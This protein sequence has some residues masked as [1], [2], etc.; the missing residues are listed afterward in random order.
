MIIM[1]L[2]NCYSLSELFLFV[3]LSVPSY[4][5]FSAFFWHILYEGFFHILIDAALRF[6]LYHGIAVKISLLNLITN[7]PQKLVCGG[8]AALSFLYCYA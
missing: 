3:F 2:C 5:Y 6:C 1:K 8:L 7:K 4:D